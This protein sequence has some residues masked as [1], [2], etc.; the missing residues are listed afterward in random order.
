MDEL[1]TNK[2]TS[3]PV[4]SRTGISCLAKFGPL[5]Y[6]QLNYCDGT[7][8]EDTSSDKTGIHVKRIHT[9]EREN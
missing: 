6:S 9:R 3:P 5:S 7:K 4:S 1:F 8:A 2:N